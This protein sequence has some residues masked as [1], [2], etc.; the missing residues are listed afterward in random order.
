MYVISGE[1]NVILIII[2]WLQKLRKDW[3]KS[4]QGAQKIDVERFNLRKLNELEV[5]RLRSQNRF[6]A[7]EDVNDSEDINGA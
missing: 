2:W 6:A 1:L 3:Q 5:L 4:K 7:L